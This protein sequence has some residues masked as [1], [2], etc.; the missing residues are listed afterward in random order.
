MWGTKERE[1]RVKGKAN[2]DNVRNCEDEV[3]IY[4]EVKT[5]SAELLNRCQRYPNYLAFRAAVLGMFY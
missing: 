1:K 5:L 2:V 3:V 4:E